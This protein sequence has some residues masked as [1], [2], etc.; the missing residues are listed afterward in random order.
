MLAIPVV[1][2]NN[3]LP[4]TLAV[5]CGFCFRGKKEQTG[6]SAQGLNQL[7]PQRTPDAG[8]FLTMIHFHDREGGLE[9]KKKEL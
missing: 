7:G 2:T 8:A 4:R 6:K 1:N 5:Q 9:K 3:S